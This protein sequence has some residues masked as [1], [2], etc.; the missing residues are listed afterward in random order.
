MTVLLL[1][2]IAEARA[3]AARLSAEGVDVLTC[4]AGAV[5]HTAAPSGRVRVGGFGGVD[6]LARY[7]HDE[8]IDLVVD[9]THPFAARITQNAAQACT[10][11]G[12]PLLRLSRPGC[13][14]LPNAPASSTSAGTWTGTRWSAPCP[15]PRG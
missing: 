4:L 6:G 14:P 8:R 9:A 7:L 2:G 13:P 10:L 15:A 1:G 5:T 11:T 3:L 12:T